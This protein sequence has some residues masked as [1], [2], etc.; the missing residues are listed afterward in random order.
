M[1]AVHEIHDGSPLHNL[2]LIQFSNFPD[3]PF[4]I[5]NM[6]VNIHSHTDIGV[7]HHILDHL[8]IQIYLRHTDTCG[9]SQDVNG[10]MRHLF[11][12]LSFPLCL[13]PFFLIIVFYNIPQDKI[14]G[15]SGLSD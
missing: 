10:N 14:N 1:N 6:I 4:L 11:R 7:S 5:R 8:D 2:N 15:A 13:L 3:N 9:I 12:L